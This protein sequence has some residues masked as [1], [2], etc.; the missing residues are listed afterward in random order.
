VSAGPPHGARQLAVPSVVQTEWRRLRPRSSR[1]RS[2]SPSV[3][4]WVGDGYRTYSVTFPELGKVSSTNFTRPTL[5]VIVYLS[6]W[7]TPSARSV[8]LLLPNYLAN[9][10]GVGL[11]V[12]VGRTIFRSVVES[13]K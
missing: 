7:P 3:V 1:G 5:S 6:S 10:I 8:V 13:G 2:F 4:N 11:V 9:A 12:L